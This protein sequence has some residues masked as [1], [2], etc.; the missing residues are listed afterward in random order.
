MCGIGMA[1]GSVLALALGRYVQSQLYGIPRSDLATVG[2]AACVLVTVA[3]AS[4]WLP[5]LHASRVDPLR[6]LRTE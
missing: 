4:G 5:A 2:G 6:A 1:L 3:L